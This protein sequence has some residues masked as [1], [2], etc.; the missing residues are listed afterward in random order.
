MSLSTV[1][2][3]G[4]LF[5]AVD[6]YYMLPAHG[7]S[8]LVKPNERDPQMMLC[9]TV[10]ERELCWPPARDQGCG[11]GKEYVVLGIKQ[12]VLVVTFHTYFFCRRGCKIVDPV[13]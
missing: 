13:P 12:P 5:A 10:D 6:H 1:P 8:L 2:P 7:T 11:D 4:I 3:P 9:I